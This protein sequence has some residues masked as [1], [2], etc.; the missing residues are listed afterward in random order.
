MGEQSTAT[1]TREETVL[2][3]LTI[4]FGVI[5]PGILKYL[6]TAAG[7]PFVGTLAWA[8]GFGCVALAFWFRWIRP[9]DITGPE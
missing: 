5:V 3:G 7:Y 2:A 4:A 6:L 8:C 1:G 9:L